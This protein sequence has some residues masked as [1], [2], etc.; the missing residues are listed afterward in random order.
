MDSYIDGPNE[1]QRAAVQAQ[2]L[3]EA[4][5][6]QHRRK[7]IGQP[8]AVADEVAASHHHS[9]GP[10]LATTAEQAHGPPPQPAEPDPSPRPTPDRRLDS[11]VAA[12]DGGRASAAAA[13]M[14]RA[15]AE[16]DRE[17][18]SYATDAGAG[19][20]PGGR[21]PTDATPPDVSGLVVS[22]GRP[23]AVRYDCY[24]G[25]ASKGAP[26]GEDGR[27]G[28]PFKVQPVRTAAD[29]LAAHTIAVDD[30]ANWL[31]LTQ[32]K[33]VQAA[34]KELKGKVLACWC[35]ELPCHAVLLRYT[36]SRGVLR[37]RTGAAARWPTRQPT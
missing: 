37:C 9:R 1:P 22:L 6:R 20:F 15:L 28:N 36:L 35:G 21:V 13:E 5:E 10:A 3:A 25:R 8:L 18:L 27:W 29:R 30:H 7:A 23:G 16:G 33:L 2:L 26:V 4:A 34:R 17:S 19:V 11:G 12:A 14:R 31:L 32:P 24:V